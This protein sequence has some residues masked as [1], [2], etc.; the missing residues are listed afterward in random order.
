MPAARGGS[1]GQPAVLFLDDLQWADEATLELLP[2]LA[3]AVREAPVLVAGSYRSDELP[4][5]HTLRTVRARLRR[6]RQLTEIMLGPLSDDEVTRML[7]ALLGGAPQPSLAAAVAGRADGLPFAVEELAIALRDSGRLA[8]VGDGVALAGAGAAPVPDGIRE[9]VLLRAARL[10]D[11]ERTLLEAAAVAG[12]EFDVD[13]VL[14]AGGLPAWPDA[15]TGAGLI[16]EVA[17]GRAAFR[18]SLTREAA[19]DEIPWTRRRRLH[20]DLARSLAANGASAA[21]VAAH[22]LAARDFAGA[23]IALVAAADAHWAVGAYRDAARALRTALEHWP[24]DDTSAPAGGRAARLAAVDRLARCAEMSADYAEAIALL[25]ELAEDQRRTGDAATLAA[26]HRR[27]AVTHELRGQWESAITD[28]EIAAGLFVTAGLPAEAAVDRLTIATQLRAAASYSAALATLSAASADA[29]SSGRA[30]LVLRA[31]GLRGN[32]LCRLGQP[33]AGIVAVRSALDQALAGE[34]A[35]TAAELHQ[36]LADSLEHSGDYRAAAAAYAAAY[37]FCDS[38]GADAIGQMCRACAAPVLFNRGDWDRV[39]AVCEDVLAAAT[40]PHAQSVATCFL[41]L[42][43]ALR[44]SSRPARRELVEALLM[45]T[46]IELVPVQLLAHWGLCVLDV[47]DGARSAAVERGRQVLSLISQTEER[48]YSL[49]ILPW[50]AGYFTGHGQLPDGLSCVAVLAAIAETTGQP[51]A[52]AG[53]AQARGITL[54]ASGQPVEAVRELLRAGEMFGE[55]DLPFAAAQAQLC[56]ALAASRPGTGDRGDAGRACQL[57]LSAHAQ[58]SQL[59]ARQL[60]DDCVA[61]LADLGHTPPRRSPARRLGAR[62]RGTLP[63][64]IR[65]YDIGRATAGLSARELDVMLL[66]ARGNTSKQVGTTL[67]ISPRTVEMHVQSSLLKL[68][69]RTRAD[70]VR[71]LAELDVLNP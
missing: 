60:R 52:I 35:D 69:C 16:T 59:G 2:A 14:A 40:I 50:L 54:E 19:Y 24:P 30:D 10:T 62:E 71:R 67:F 56:A 23:R 63:P 46:R 43:H 47:A 1:G 12:L 41:G 4:R 31:E 29:K 65:P 13:T 61:A 8:H 55:L 36:R 42:V 51:E 21:L 45:A 17:D 18:H 64:G 6:A 37:Q 48:H 44:G 27:L 38:H 26:T 34:L 70:A 5:G 20:R 3:D 28:R 49:A 15:F 9:A 7:A 25:R 53:L 32:V 39:V 68:Q 22:L 58:A 33:D 66:V 11:S 57:L